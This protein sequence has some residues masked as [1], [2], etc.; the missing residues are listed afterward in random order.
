MSRPLRLRVRIRRREDR[1]SGLPDSLLDHI[2]SFLPTKDAVATSILSKRWK[3]IWRSQR[4]IYLD[5]TSFPHTAAFR[6]F[7]N[8]FITMRDN[9]LPILSFH[10]KSRHRCNHLYQDFVYPAITKGKVENLIIDLFCHSYTLPPS[11]LLLSS[12]TLSVLKLKRI[13]LNEGF[14]TVVDLPLLKVLHLESVT[15]IYIAD[16]HKLVSACPILQ[17]LQT[18][19]LRILTMPPFPL[20]RKQT[21]PLP[22]PPPPLGIAISNLV[23]ANI[24]FSDDDSIFGLEWLHNVDHLHIQLNTTSPTIRADGQEHLPFVSIVL[25]WML[26]GESLRKVASVHLIDVKVPLTEPCSSLEYGTKASCGYG[27]GKYN[28]DPKVYCGNTKEI[29][30]KRVTTTACDEPYRHVSWDGIHATEAAASPLSCFSLHDAI[31]PPRKDGVE[32]LSK[33]LVGTLLELMDGIS[34]NGGLVVIAA[35]NRP[36]HIDPALRQGGR[37]D[38][39]I[40]IANW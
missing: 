35:T 29:Y 40:E 5:D 37:F 25:E 12:K 2:L 30:G 38:K 23:I 8:S 3:P 34:I 20:R 26:K 14:P 6:Q 9:T 4:I 1:L 39:D 10:L 15:F 21:P 33:R 17:E 13:E 7:F 11:I 36:D 18:N 28:F 22:P 31:A 24:I 27:G 32:V 19:Y 16:L